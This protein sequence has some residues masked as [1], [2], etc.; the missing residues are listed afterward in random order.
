MIV[1]IAFSIAVIAS[2][3]YVMIFGGRTGRWGGGILLAT[4]P[5]S[6]AVAPLNHAY[7]RGLPDLFLVDLIVLVGLVAVALASTRRW[8]VWVAAFQLNTVAAHLAI[9]LSPAVLSQAYYGMITIWGVPMLAAMVIGTWLDRKFQSTHED[10]N[11]P[12]ETAKE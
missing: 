2:C 8:P 5:L 1:P 11:M 7:G 6:W 4:W 9:M 3:A 12:L 10:G